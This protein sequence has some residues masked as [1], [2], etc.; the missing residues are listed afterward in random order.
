MKYFTIEELSHSNTAIAM[1]LNNKPTQDVATKIADLINNCLDP[2]R[3]AYGEPI[4]VNSGYRCADLNR[5]L[6]GAKNS[7]HLK[8]EAADIT[9]GSRTENKKIYELAK[10]LPKGFDQLIWEK[11]DDTGPQWV[12]ISWKKEGNRNQLLRL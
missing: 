11:G 1:K 9:G 3:K 6:K 5:I 2:L 10:K 7:Q 12:H 4:K 8:G